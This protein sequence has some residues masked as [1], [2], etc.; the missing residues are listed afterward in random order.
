MTPTSPARRSGVPPSS[1]GHPPVD[2]SGIIQP[3]VHA[4]AAAALARHLGAEGRPASPHADLSVTG[5]AEQLSPRAA[6]RRAA[7]P[8]RGRAPMGDRAGQLPGLGRAV[9][10]GA[11]RSLALRRPTPAATLTTRGAGERPT[12]EDYARYIRLALAYRDPGYDDDW[13]RAE[14]EFLVIDPGIQRLMGL[15]GAGAGRTRRAPRRRPGTASD[16]SR[17]H[18]RG[19]GRRVVERTTR[20]FSSPGTRAPGRRSVSGPSAGCCRWCCPV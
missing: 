10:R 16:R 15:V 1:D 9:A 8:R 14:G 2:T 13:V 11:G 3:P 17:P 18:H 7:R 5:R 20:H 4:V 6:G 12:D 19:D